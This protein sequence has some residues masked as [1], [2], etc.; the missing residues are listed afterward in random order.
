MVL[1]INQISGDRSR[2]FGQRPLLAADWKH[3]TSG[4]DSNV[5]GPSTMPNAAGP[6]CLESA[7]GVNIYKRS[8]V[9]GEKN[10]TKHFRKALLR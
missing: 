5:S 7:A 3:H 10:E 8:G 1:P 2:S 6:T 9:P 4:D